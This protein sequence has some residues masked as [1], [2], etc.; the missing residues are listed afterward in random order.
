MP[1]R[2]QWR[3]PRLGGLEAGDYERN[4]TLAGHDEKREPLHR[5]AHEA[6]QVS[7]VRA[8]ADEERGKSSFGDC[9]SAGREAG[10][11]SVG[12][13]L[14]EWLGHGRRVARLMFGCLSAPRN[15]GGRRPMPG[16]LA[17]CKSP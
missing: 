16:I 13:D 2:G 10:G 3:G 1:A 4:G 15:S 14:A 7:E 17:K 12:W 9:F 8:D 5:L 6:G 11:I